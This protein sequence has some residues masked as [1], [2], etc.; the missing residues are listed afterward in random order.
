S[1]QTVGDLLA[2]VQRGGGWISVPIRDGAGQ[3]TTGT[4]PTVG[5][6]V[7]GCVHVWRGHSGMWDIEARDKHGSGQL[8]MSAGAGESVPFTY[9]AGMRAELEVDFSWSEQRDTTLYLWVGL[10]RPNQDPASTCR[11]VDG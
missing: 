10:A 6:T 3:L 9:V 7:A 5:L 4:L 8:K 2:S 1:G 11:P